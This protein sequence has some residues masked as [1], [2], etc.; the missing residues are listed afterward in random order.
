[1]KKH[2]LLF[3]IMLGL[4]TMILSQI[5]NYVPSNGLVGW[6]PFSG[7]ANDLSGNGNNGTLNGPTLT[8]DRLGLNNSAYNFD[9]LN[10][11][12]EVQNAIDFN[13]TI[14]QNYCLSFWSLVNS[15]DIVNGDAISKWDNG[16]GQYPFKVQF[17]SLSNGASI[18][19]ARYGGGLPQD[20][21][22]IQYI[23]DTIN[24]NVFNHVVINFNQ[25][26]GIS[27]YLNGV[28]QGN[29]NVN[30]ISSISNNFPLYFGRRGGASNRFFKG[31]IDDIGIWN[32][33]LT[34]QEITNLYDG[35]NLN[36]SITNQSSLVGQ[37]VNFNATQFSNTNYQWQT[38][39]ANNGWQNVNSNSSYSGA[40][41]N[42][43]AINNVQLSNHNQPFRVIT[44][45]GTCIDTSNV[46]S[47]QINDTCITNV[48]LYDTTYVTVTDTNVITVY[49]T[50]LTTVTDT[51]IINTT[52]GLPAPNNENTILIYPNPASDQITIDNGNYIAMAGYSI[53]IENNAGQQVFQSNINQ[54]LFTIDLNTWSGDG[55]YFV[56]LIDGQ[57]NTVTVRKIVLQ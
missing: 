7:N 44:T 19:L 17:S 39:P 14:S 28:F 20:Q 33:V 52:L 40:T 41:T 46:A 29:S 48:T 26:T 57:G 51:L 37:N 4:N 36:V 30:S 43:L 50:L 9:G 32:R 34:Q 16:F 23:T 35:C 12:I 38:N 11:W 24:S 3:T 5:P 21:T 25:V 49:D 47:L 56:H 6:W 45:A 2:T 15:N 22:T 10:D 18:N 31:K 13:F 54:Q 53:K 8:T 27:Y 1:M 55:L 42:N